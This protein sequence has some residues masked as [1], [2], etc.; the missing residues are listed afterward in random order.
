MSDILKERLSRFRWEHSSRYQ[1]MLPAGTVDLSEYNE[2]LKKDLEQLDRLLDEDPEAYRKMQLSTYYR[3]GDSP[4]YNEL[5]YALIYKIRFCSMYLL[6]YYIIYR[7]LIPRLPELKINELKLLVLGCGSMIDALSLFHVLKETGTS[8]P[9]RYTG[10]DMVRW[11]SGYMIPFE[12][13]FIQKPLQDYWDDVEVFDGNIIFFATVLSELREYPDQTEM[14]C[15]GLENTPFTSDTIFLLVAYRSAASYMNDW[16]LTDWQKAQ[17]VIAAIEKKGYKAEDLPVSLPEKWDLYLHNGKARSE[18]GRD[19]TSYY[20]AAPY[21]PDKV[22]RVDAVAPDFASPDYVREYLEKPGYI[23][24]HCSYYQ[25]RKEQY[26][27][28][29]PETE[30]QETDIPIEI[31]SKECPIICKPFPRAYLS[32]T[33]SP[34]FQIVVFHKN[35]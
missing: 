11:P 18:D 6:Q 16:K 29:N 15:R 27:K 28:H 34:C 24:K 35:T 19:W 4:D 22:T 8:I 12:T 32:K 30:N 2:Q 23:R 9:V 17:R 33:Y 31:C 25:M 21:G 3:K 14:F 1:P 20:L 5:I 26:R 10:V 7:L 13:N